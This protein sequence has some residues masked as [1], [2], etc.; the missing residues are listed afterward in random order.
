MALIQAGLALL[1][2]GLTPCQTAL[3]LL[4]AALLRVLPSACAFC[5]SSSTSNKGA[6]IGTALLLL[7]L[8]LG[9]LSACV[10]WL[11]RRSR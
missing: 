7:G 5:A 4:N 3:A 10:L 6:Y 9:F 11:I 8:P 2:A 1:H